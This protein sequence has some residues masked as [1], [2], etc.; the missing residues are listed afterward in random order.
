MH[1]YLDSASHLVFPFFLEK[2][3]KIVLNRKVTALSPPP[4]K[5]IERERERERERT[6]WINT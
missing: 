6:L 5:E 3:K 4:R 2:E 1:H